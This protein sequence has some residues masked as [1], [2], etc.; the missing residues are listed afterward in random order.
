MASLIDIEGVGE[1]YA[2]KLKAAG[3]G[4]QEKLLELGSTPKGREELAL[5]TGISEKLILE[6]V[7][8]CDLMRVKGVGS[9]YSDLLEAAGVDT[10]P[11]LAKRVP[12]NLLAKM[13]EVNAAKKLVRKMPVLTQVEDWVAQ[14]KALPRVVNY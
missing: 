5:K 4:T 9:E 14:A 1:T 3:V 10:V 12:A 8:R 13:T 6:W 11:E 7:N 2:A